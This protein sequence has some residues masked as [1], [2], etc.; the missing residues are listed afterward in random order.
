M[1]EK[2]PSSKLDTW[3]PIGAEL[4]RRMEE[5]LGE[6]KGEFARVWWVEEDAVREDFAWPEG[7]FDAVIVPLAW[8]QVADKKMFVYKCLSVLRGDGLLLMSVLGSESFKEV[9][10]VAGEG[11]APLPDVRAAGDLLQR[12]KVA[13]PVVDRDVI[14]LTFKDLEGLKGA[15]AGAG[16]RVPEGE[17]EETYVTRHGREDGR[18]SATLEVIWLQGFRPAEGQPVAAKRGTGKVSLVRILGEG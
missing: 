18:I 11:A 13:L 4:T 12:L 16:E 15:M 1:R 2:M 17:W 9:W 10:E 6:V 14:A 8:A 5:R 7:P 3:A